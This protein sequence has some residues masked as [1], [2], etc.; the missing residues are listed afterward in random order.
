MIQF[1]EIQ[2]AETVLIIAFVMTFV[3]ILLGLAISTCIDIGCLYKNTKQKQK[4][5]ARRYCSICRD[6]HY[7]N[8]EHTPMQK[9]ERERAPQKTK[10]DRWREN[11]SKQETQDSGIVKIPPV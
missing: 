8:S 5:R 3:G 10:E 11:W 1:T 9:R 4:R 2:F 6:Y 7:R